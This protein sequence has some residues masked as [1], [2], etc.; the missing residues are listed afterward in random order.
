MLGALCLDVG[1]SVLCNPV[2]DAGRKQSS[3]SSTQKIVLAPHPDQLLGLMPSP[4]GHVSWPL[5]A[6]GSALLQGLSTS[7]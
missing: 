3:L 1:E 2:S 5:T 4:S 6:P 7:N